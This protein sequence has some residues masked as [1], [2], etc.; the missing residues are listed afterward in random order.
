MWRKHQTEFLNIVSNIGDV[1][2]IIC[3]VTPGGG[4]S[5]IP[6]IAAAKL[7]PSF[8]KGICW[9]V[10]RVALQE[11]AETAFTDPHFRRLLNHKNLIR[12][13]T[14]KTNPCRG[15]TGFVTT[16]AACVM[17]NQSILEEFKKR[18]FI[19]VLDE[20]HHISERGA[21]KKA[22]EPLMDAAALQVLMSGT[23]ERGSKERIAFVRYSEGVEKDE[24][25]LSENN[26]S[27][28]IS[29]GRVD[30][31]RERSII[32]LRVTYLDSDA[33][34]KV[35]DV[36]K[37]SETLQEEDKRKRRA[38]LFTALSTGFS[39]QLLDAAL[40]DWKKTKRQ[41][42]RAKILIVAATQKMAREYADYCYEKHGMLCGVATVNE[43]VN[44][45]QNI[46]RFKRIKASSGDKL[47]AISTVGMAYEGLDVKP[48]THIAC[49]T[50][51]RSKPWIEQMLA[52]ATRYDAE[53]G[54]WHSQEAHVF[55][56]DDPDMHGVI[57]KIVEEEHEAVHKKSSAP[58]GSIETTPENFVQPSL[59]G[60]IVPMQSKASSIRSKRIDESFG[61]SQISEEVSTPSQ[62]EENLRVS[63]NDR[64]KAF[65]VAHKLDFRE[66]NGRIKRKFG[67]ARDDM[68]IDELKMLRRW[69]EENF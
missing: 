1:K 62:I 24:I 23:L 51:I 15:L 13:S 19:L 41:N 46:R 48:I 68:S 69:V 14:N 5:A 52:R 31:L 29:Y 56:P 55:A 57:D 10:P 2:K 66:I 33:E 61:D 64:V 38:A 30:A 67:K 45:M 54:S 3:H 4:K 17:S 27:R 16:Y 63:V 34:W 12:V 65:A 49:L 47:D 8:A 53:A 18:R 7:I 39:K 11:Q 6:V 28:T 37:R 40:A 35:G 22:I 43:G 42:P 50:R 44:A 60:G 36:I 25:D 32:P 9:I 20:P 21:Y 26:N 58:T 59:F